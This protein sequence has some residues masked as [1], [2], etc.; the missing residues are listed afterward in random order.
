MTENK[1]KFVEPAN[2]SDLDVLAA[3]LKNSTDRAE[4]DRLVAIAKRKNFLLPAA[5]AGDVARTHQESGGC[6]MFSANGAEDAPAAM[7]QS[8]ANLLA[9]FSDGRALIAKMGLKGDPEIIG[10][11]SV[12]EGALRAAADKNLAYTEQG[13]AI[14][15]R[16]GYDSMAIERMQRPS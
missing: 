15:K 1:S 9:S 12:S 2:Q 4:R 16:R 8:R 7:T 11:G 10:G 13:R 5:F 14:L 6:A 3:R